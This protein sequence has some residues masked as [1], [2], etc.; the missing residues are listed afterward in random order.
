M[1]TPRR[2]R[3]PR[4]RRPTVLQWR[5]LQ[6]RI[7]TLQDTLPW[8]SAKQSRKTWSRSLEMVVHGLLAADRLALTVAG[9]GFCRCAG[10][11]DEA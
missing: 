10:F 7:Q 11:D 8:C 3:L 9:V 1:H 4:R 5:R 2:T 6:L